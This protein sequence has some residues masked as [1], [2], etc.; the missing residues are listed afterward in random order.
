[1][2]VEHAG[3]VCAK[4]E[5]ADKFYKDVLGLTKQ[6]P[7]ILDRP[8]SKA[9]FGVDAEIKMINYTDD[10]NH[11]EIF[12]HDCETKQQPI[13]EHLCLEVDDR[14][15][16]LDR[17]RDHGVSINS[18]QKGEKVVVFIWDFDKNLFEIKEK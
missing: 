18:I 13:I 16:F 10:S 9:I 7:K 15:R 6:E 5:T 11:F 2:R 8:L 17:C 1:M 4:E 12:I 14:T 3:L